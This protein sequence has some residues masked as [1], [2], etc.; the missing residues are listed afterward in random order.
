MPKWMHW[1]G[2]AVAVAVISAALV[3]STR[4]VD[5]QQATAPS[6]SLTPAQQTVDLSAGTVTVS[7][8]VHNVPAQAGFAN[9]LGSFGFTLRYDKGV[10]ADPVAQVSSFLGSTGKQ[11]QCLPAVID[12]GSGPGTIK[13]GCA[14]VGDAAGPTGSGTLATVT[15]HLAGGS[16][17]TIYVEKDTVA[18]P[19]EWPL[20]RTDGFNNHPIDNDYLLTCPATNGSV[21]VN[22][23]S[24]TGNEG[25]SA[26]PTPSDVTTGGGT[27]TTTDESQPT[28]TAAGG[29][30]NSA[31]AGGG[32]PVAGAT[33]GSGVLGTQSGGSAAGAPVASRAGSGTSGAQVARLGSGPPPQDHTMARAGVWSALALALLGML[34]LGKGGLLFW[35]RRRQG[36]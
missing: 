21:T 9:G 25:V 1:A 34:A 23:G 28:A 4:A 31:A 11:V 32:S 36:E 20:C 27:R 3:G 5:A 14:T 15:F 30:N 16:N 29:G 10:L 26:T 7:V 35:A 6:F 22:G 17:T 2:A 19:L 12:G 18:D 13:F 8:E 24:S 33:P